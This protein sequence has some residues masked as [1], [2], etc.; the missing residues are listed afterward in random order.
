M[1]EGD[2][3]GAAAAWQQLGAP[4]E[5]ALASGHAFNEPSSIVSSVKG[6]ALFK[7]I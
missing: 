1:I 6:I 7:F 2:W 4:Y 5:R 3:E